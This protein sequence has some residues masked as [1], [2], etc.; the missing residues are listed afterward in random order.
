MTAECKRYNPGIKHSF[1]DSGFPCAHV[2]ASWISSLLSS[3][4]M[5]AHEHLSDV[6]LT[7]IN[8]H[9]A[10]MVG[11]HYLHASY[12][13]LKICLHHKTCRDSSGKDSIS[14]VSVLDSWSGTTGFMRW[15]EYKEALFPRY[16]EEMVQHNGLSAGEI[17][18]PKTSDKICEYHMRSAVSLYC[19]LDHAP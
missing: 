4:L 6:H 5:R 19:M 8:Q 11:A 3:R 10:K 15:Q 1:P 7:F 17:I 16:I 13:H 9:T 14:I 18:F 12:I 2:H